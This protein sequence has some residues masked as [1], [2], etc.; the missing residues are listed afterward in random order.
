V[1]VGTRSYLPDRGHRVV[2][3]PELTAQHYGYWR[4]PE[5]FAETVEFLEGLDC[6][7]CIVSDID[8]DDLQAAMAVHG[9]RFEHV[10]KSEDA[11]P[12]KP[13][14]EPSGT[15]R[16]T[17]PGGGAALGCRTAW[18]NRR[19]PSVPR[20]TPDVEVRS[21]IALTRVDAIHDGNAKP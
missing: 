6:P 20:T 11:R 1:P 4:R 18:V 13:R 5:L 15:R 7:V 3:D 21:L 8:R 16:P 2:V 17:T 12:Y 14:P 9:L 19:S 10:V